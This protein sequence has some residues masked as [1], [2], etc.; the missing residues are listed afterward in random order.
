[1]C[2]SLVRLRDGYKLPATFLSDWSGFQFALAVRFTK[3]LWEKTIM[4]RP[5]LV[6]AGSAVATIIS[7]NTLALAA[8]YYLDSVGGDDAKDGNTEAT[9]KKT[10]KMPSGSGNTVYLKRG[11]SWTTS[12]NASNVKVTTY[13]SGERPI[14]NGAVTVNNA[15]VEGLHSMTTKGNGMNVQSNS[16]VRDCDIDGANNTSTGVAMGVNGTGNKIL[17]NYVHDFK[18]S[19]SG[20]EMDNS[21]GAEGIM[22]MASDNEVGFNRAVNLYSDNATLGGYE[23]GC[24]EIVNGKA[25]STISNVSFHHNYCERSVGLWEGCSGDFSATGGA[26]QENHAIIENVTVSYNVSVDSMWMYL[27][28]PVNTDF[29]NVVFAHNTNI[30]TPKSKEWWPNSNGYSSMAM[31][32]ATYT[33]S[34]AGKT[35][36]T[37]NQ[38]FKKG[39]GFQP[40]TIIV[41]NNIFVDTISS[42]PSFGLFTSDLTDHSNNIFAPANANVGSLKLAATDKKVALADLAFTADYRLTAASVA[43][44][45]Q[46]ATVGMTGNGSLAVSALK[47][48]YFASVF[49]QDIDTHPVPS[50]AAPDVGASEYCSDASCTS[51][52]GG[53]PSTGGA[54]SVTNGGSAS[55][56]GASSTS[57]GGRVSVGGTSTVA[58]GG[59]AANG[60][61]SSSVASSGSSAATS[62]GGSVANTGGS[63]SSSSAP[64]AGTGGSN[65]PGAGGNTGAVNNGGQ[66]SSSPAGGDV[67]VVGASGAQGSGTSTNTGAPPTAGGQS[68]SVTGVPSQDG[69]CAC[70]LSGTSRN[71]LGTVLVSVGLA[72]LALG[73]RRRR[74]ATGP[75]RS[76]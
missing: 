11:S 76:A 62:N 59:N 47:P 56:G 15:T 22:V 23:G 73:R 44:I 65:A 8:D 6:W 71:G 33:N 46:G 64:P 2:V 10:F 25:L 9:A 7:A 4:I 70:R 75:H 36:E 60:G 51:T 24:F 58:I 45:D 19:V 28:Q 74:V 1:M 34:A 49:N 31:V 18:F 12:L 43:A 20:G 42:S 16:I 40:G 38:Y 35:Y 53:S 29:R 72:V 27:L 30:H 21:G 68:G 67:G 61:A 41:K 3:A 66:A 48:E 50:G 14:I 37:D 55:G 13:G 39:A 52:A 17:G 54:T 5:R 26:I 57:S 69:G 63:A 32:V